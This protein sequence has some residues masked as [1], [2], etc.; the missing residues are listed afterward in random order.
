ME[1]VLHLVPS[2]IAWFKGNVTGLPPIYCPFTGKNPREKPLKLFP[3]NRNPS[4]LQELA[5]LGA[6]RAALPTRLP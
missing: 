4:E 6:R 1:T 3:S 2:Q 5:D